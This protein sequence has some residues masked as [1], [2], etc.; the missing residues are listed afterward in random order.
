MDLP[1]ANGLTAVSMRIE[2]RTDNWGAA[3]IR[4][5]ASNF[6]NFFKIKFQKYH[7]RTVRGTLSRLEN[8]LMESGETSRVTG[9]VPP[10]PSSRGYGHRLRLVT[11]ASSLQSS[12]A[13]MSPTTTMSRAATTSEQMIN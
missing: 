12:T 3:A 8:S 9:P 5:R 4:F 6:F 10:T 13:N 2:G 7:H 1:S 11:S